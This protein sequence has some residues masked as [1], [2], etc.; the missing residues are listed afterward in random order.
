MREKRKIRDRV[1]LK[2]IIPGDKPDFAE[3]DE[4]FSLRVT[5][6]KKVSFYCR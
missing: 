5:K 6:A 1:Q 3:E 4:L 2:M